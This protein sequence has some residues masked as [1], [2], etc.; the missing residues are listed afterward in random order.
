MEDILDRLK[1]KYPEHNVKY[2]PQPNCDACAGTGEHKNGYGEMTLC[3]CTCVS[4]DG[5]GGLFK[6][7]VSKE[8]SELR[9][10]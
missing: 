8:L 6:D 10:E 5:I 7:F 1:N 9:G 3:I 2:H 4:L